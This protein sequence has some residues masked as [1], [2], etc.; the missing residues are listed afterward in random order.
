MIEPRGVVRIKRL[1]ATRSRLF[2][3]VGGLSVGLECFLADGWLSWTQPI[4]VG[5]YVVV[6]ASLF[7]AMRS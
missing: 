1:L 7:V 4:Q 6:G 5:G 3:V 2:L